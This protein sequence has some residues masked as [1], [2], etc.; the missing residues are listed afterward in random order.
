MLNIKTLINFNVHTN[1]DTVSDLLYNLYEV[2]V[3]SFKMKNE[4]THQK[5]KRRDQ[6]KIE[7]MIFIYM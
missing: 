4:E 2:L 5:E 7:N 6:L 1:H 3:R